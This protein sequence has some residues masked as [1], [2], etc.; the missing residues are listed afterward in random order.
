MSEEEIA[1]GPI[2]VVDDSEGIRSYLSTLLR[3]WGYQVELVSSGEAALSFI[4]EGGTPGLVLLD[5]M[6]PGMGG[7]ETLERIRKVD[8]MLPVVIISVVSRAG[9]IVEAMRVG[10]ADFINKPFEESELR[11]TVSNL[12]PLVRVPESVASTRIKSDD[13]IW[14]SSSMAEILRVIKQISDTDV[15]VLV[16]GESGVGKEVVA[17]AIHEHSN[18]SSSTF[19]KVNC[20]ALPEDLLES[21]LFGYEKGAFTGANA[22]KV[23]KFEVADGGTIFLDEIGEMSPGLQAKLLQVLQD[24][25]FNRLGGNKE[26]SVDVR[27][28]CATHRNLPEMVVEKSFREDLYFRLNVVNICIPPLRDQREMIPKLVAHFVSRYGD[29]YRRPMSAVS[30]RL[31]TLMAS[32]SFPGNV[33]ELENMIKRVIV[34]ES[35]ASILSELE[36][37]R[38]LSSAR[39]S[40]LYA[41]LEEVAESAGAIPLREVSRRASL[42]V[43]KEAIGVIL[44][45]AGWNRKQ[46]AKM[47][48]ISYKTLLQKIRDCDLEAVR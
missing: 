22:R 13:R 2:L 25:S 41:L 26:I 47:L 34:L 36:G 40:N 11:A 3:S 17:R 39:K 28:V 5:L 43:E 23:G 4:E 10:A 29:Q 20:A 30:D 24:S 8:E 46:A 16:H 32:Y 18:R 6:L 14:E 44:D 21:E 33:R 7:V 15:T 12:L 37:R 19:V 38:T 1:R 27:V 9:T 45:Q 35:E 31:M 42:E 48:G